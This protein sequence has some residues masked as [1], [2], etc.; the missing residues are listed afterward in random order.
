MLLHIHI[1]TLINLARAWG[2]TCKAGPPS[3]TW[4]T[5]S[6]LTLLLNDLHVA[7]SPQVP[8]TDQYEVIIYQL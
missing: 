7:S 6:V 8:L 4:M 2:H 3:G 5:D 1:V